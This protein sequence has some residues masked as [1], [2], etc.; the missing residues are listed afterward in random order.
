MDLFREK[1]SDSVR[2]VAAL[3]SLSGFQ[4]HQRGGHE[5][6]D[7]EECDHD[8]RGHHP[9]EIDDGPDSAEQQRTERHYCRDRGV[10]AWH[11]L[12]TNHFPDQFFLSG[13]R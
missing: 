12:G 6:E 3:V 10:Q 7:Q 9:A 4:E 13:I 11:G 8:A 2:Q 5:R 1:V